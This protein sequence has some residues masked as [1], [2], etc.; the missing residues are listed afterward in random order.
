M[1]LLTNI[2]ADYKALVKFIIFLRN[3]SLEYNANAKGKNKM[4]KAN[5]TSNN[6]TFEIIATPDLQGQ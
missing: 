4:A 1:I 3:K 2:C 5:F 6:R